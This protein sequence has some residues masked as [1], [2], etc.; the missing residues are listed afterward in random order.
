MAAISVRELVD[1]GVHFGHHASRWNPKMSPFIHGK[2]NLI[3]IINLVETVKGL[4]R[5][6]HFL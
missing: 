6:R 1:A 3:H 5:A 2:R 4:T